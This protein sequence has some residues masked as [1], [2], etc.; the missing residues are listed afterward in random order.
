MDIPLDQP[1]S[2]FEPGKHIPVVLIHSRRC[3]Q[4][5][6]ALPVLEKGADFVGSQAVRFGK[7]DK[8]LVIEA[9][10]PSLRGEPQSVFAVP[11]DVQHI[12]VRQPLGRGVGS[13]TGSIELHCSPAGG[14]PQMIVLI[15][16]DIAHAEGG[17]AV[18]NT[19]GAPFPLPHSCPRFH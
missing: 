6:V 7:G 5:Q 17:Q 13:K 11:M 2:P 16:N 14:E 18:G 12:V 10:D 1:F 4:Q 3:P 9:A 19:Q 8:A 15:L